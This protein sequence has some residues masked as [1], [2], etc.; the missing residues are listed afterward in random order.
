MQTVCARLKHITSGGDG[1]ITALYENRPNSN[2]YFT[3]PEGNVVAGYRDIINTKE[4][5]GETFGNAYFF[6]SK[7]ITDFLRNDSKTIDILTYHVDPINIKFELTYVSQGDFAGSYQLKMDSYYLEV[8]ND[9]LIS[10]FIVSKFADEEIDRNNPLFEPT[11]YYF[12]F[13]GNTPFERSD[14]AHSELFDIIG[15]YKKNNIRDDGACVRIE[16]ALY[17]V[18]LISEEYL[19]EPINNIE[20]IPDSNNEYIKRLYNA[21]IMCGVDSAG[22][23]DGTGTVT[24]AQLAAIIARIINPS[25]RVKL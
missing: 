1:N 10:N 24:R 2:I 4:E 3:D 21:G 22:N 20:A 6:L 7:D 12:L 23:F 18:S 14:S 15:E 25:L 11:I 19:L 17:L 5:Y 9:L 16:L 13:F 8:L